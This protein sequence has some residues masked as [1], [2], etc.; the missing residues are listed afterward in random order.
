[1]R[2]V[3]GCSCLDA[4][5]FNMSIF[6]PPSPKYLPSAPISVLLID[7]SSTWTWW[8][9]P[10]RRRGSQV[11]F[12]PLP[13]VRRETCIRQVHVP[14]VHGGRGRHLPRPLC[15]SRH[16]RGHPCDVPE[17]RA[18]RAG[19]WGPLWP[20]QGPHAERRPKTCF[21]LCSGC[22][23]QAMFRS[24]LAFLAAL[25]GAGRQGRGPGAPTSVAYRA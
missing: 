15:C 3:F 22:V 10:E 4:Q 12:L 7:A 2:L 14:Q 17:G 25:L 11:R 9:K 16:E 20:A 5:T 8:I 1:M 18:M 6:A 23:R 13:G 24:A 19:W 21:S